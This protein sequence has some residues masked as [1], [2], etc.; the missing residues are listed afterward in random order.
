M[1][2][3]TAAFRPWI[4]EIASRK[5][6]LARHHGFNIKLLRREVIHYESERKLTARAPKDS[7]S[8]LVCVTSIDDTWRPI[9]KLPF[10]DVMRYLEQVCKNR[11]LARTFWAKLCRNNSVVLET[12]G[13]KWIREPAR[14]SFGE[15]YM[16]RRSSTDSLQEQK[17]IIGSGSRRHRSR[18]LR[19]EQQAWRL[20]NEP[21]HPHNS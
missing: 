3:N 21:L 11:C 20:P 9:E 14:S 1:G 16:E 6:T 15:D 17:E 12:E 8:K 2:R 7:Q 5:L 13:W 4:F 10:S 19:W 18:T